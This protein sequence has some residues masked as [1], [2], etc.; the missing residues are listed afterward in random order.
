MKTLFPQYLMSIVLLYVVFNGLSIHVSEK[1][2]LQF[3]FCKK[4][5]RNNPS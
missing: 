3:T 4:N 5:N 2:V 1:I